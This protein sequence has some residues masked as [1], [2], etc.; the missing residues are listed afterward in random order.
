M[1]EIIPKIPRS[2]M[3]YWVCNRDETVIPQ[4]YGFMNKDGNWYIMEDNDATGVTRYCSG[5]NASDYPT[6]WT[7]RVSLTYGY[8]NESFK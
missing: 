1:A 4:Y 2:V 3:E 7:N 8:P 5:A 6:N